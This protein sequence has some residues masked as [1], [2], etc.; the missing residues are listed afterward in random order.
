[1]KCNESVG[2]MIDVLYGEEMNPNSCYEF[3]QHL[4]ICE[5]CK[6][7]YF[8]MLETR[9]LL[10]EWNEEGSETTNSQPRFSSPSSRDVRWIVRWWPTAQRLAAGILMVLGVVA[11]L[12]SMGFLASEKVMVSEAAL[13]EM[14]H[15]LILIEQGS[16][17]QLMLRALLE[18]KEDIELT[19][20]QRSQELQYYLVRLEERYVENLEGNN[21][22]LKTLLSR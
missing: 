21:R 4:E 7:E 18:V 14:V 15:D 6:R 16:E 20:V 5:D 11:I 22:Y 8:G 2:R 3:F 19:Q 1:M 12:Q 13:T 17:R 9:E 10:G